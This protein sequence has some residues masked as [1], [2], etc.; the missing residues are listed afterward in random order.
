MMYLYARAIR[1]STVTL[2]D[3]QDKIPLAVRL[4]H[5]FKHQAN[6]ARHQAIEISCTMDRC[7]GTVKSMGT[8][9]TRSRY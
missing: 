8:N 4:I 2:Y 3:N 7:F 6:Y 9:A 1:S 5:E